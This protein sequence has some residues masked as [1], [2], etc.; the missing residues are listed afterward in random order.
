MS[1]VGTPSSSSLLRHLV[2]DNPMTLEATR[3]WRHFLRSGAETGSRGSIINIG[4]LA[5][6]YLWLLVAIVRYREDMSAVL[7]ILEAA[8]LTL[9]VP[10]SMYAAVSGE[11]ERLTW[12]GLIMTSLTPGQIVIGKLVWRVALIVAVAALY[13]PPLLLSHFFALGLSTGRPDYSLGDLF[14]AQ[15]LNMAWG[16][17]L[18]GFSLWVSTRTKRTVTTL[19]IVTIT[20]LNFLF[21]VPMLLA[22][23]GGHSR[24]SLFDPPLLQLGSLLQHLNPLDG[25][26]TLSRTFADGLPSPGADVQRDLWVDNHSVYLVPWIYLGAAFACILG[27]WKTLRGLEEPRVRS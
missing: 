22:L 7:L 20:L 19:A 18:A 17:L 14:I 23:F 27:A 9:I 5:L 16:L 25:L 6:L 3:V 26:T 15:G 11:R 2:L 24:W 1:T 13:L 10:G 4:L 8:L 12:D 21:L